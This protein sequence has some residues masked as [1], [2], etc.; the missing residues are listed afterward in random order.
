MINKNIKIF[1]KEYWNI[2]NYEQAVNDDKMWDLHHRLEVSDDGLHTVYTKKDLIENGLYSNRPTSEL[3]FLTKSD[4]RK[5]HNNTIE[6]KEKLIGIERS[7]ETRKK[8]SIAQKGRH[9]SEET[10]QKIKNAQIRFKVICLNNMKIYNSLLEAGEDL[11]VNA[12]NIMKVCKGERHHT[13]GLK[14]MYYDEYERLNNNNTD[15]NCDSVTL[16]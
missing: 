5:L 4:H 9:L 16:F 6:F 10:I 11:D 1:C 8:M 15:N 13:G 14:F 3:I 2:E 7:D 12:G